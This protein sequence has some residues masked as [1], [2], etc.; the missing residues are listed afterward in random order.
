MYQKKFVRNEFISFF[1]EAYEI[2]IEID[3]DR[4]VNFDQLDKPVTTDNKLLK[5]QPNSH[6]KYCMTNLPWRFNLY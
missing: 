5:H 4:I 2:S 3:F 6:T 1:E